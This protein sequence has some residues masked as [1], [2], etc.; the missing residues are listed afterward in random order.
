MDKLTKEFTEE[1]D[2]GDSGQLL[3]L[4]TELLVLIL[5]FLRSFRDKIKFRYVSRRL[6]SVIETPSL[7]REFVW[8]YYDDREEVC[9]NNVLKT[10][11]KYVK[12]MAFPDHVTA[13][14]LVEMLQYC[15]GVT[16]L[17]LP[18]GTKFN[19]RQLRKS[20]EHMGHLECLDV[21]W[22]YGNVQPLLSIGVNLKELTVYV[23]Q[24]EPRHWMWGWMRNGFVPQT[25]NIITDVSISYVMEL[26]EAWPPANSYFGPSHFATLKFY[27]SLKVPLYIVPAMPK[28]QLQYG[29]MATLPFTKASNF[30][31]LGLEKDLLLITDSIFGGKKVR[32]AVTV[33]NKM[34][35]IQ[36][37]MPLRE[38]NGLTWFEATE[39][40]SGHLEQLAI[41]CPNLQQLKLQRN[42]NCLRSLQGLRSIAS[43]CQNL[44][45]L[46]LI[47]ISVNDVEDQMQLWEILSCMKKLT[48][49]CVDFCL[50]KHDTTLEERINCSCNLVLRAL[51]VHKGDVQSCSKCGTYGNF[52]T[53]LQ[54]SHFPMLSYCKLTKF[55]LHPSM[56]H[57]LVNSCSIL[58]SLII[59]CDRCFSLSRE[60]SLA[61]NYNLKQ[62]CLSS[63]WAVISDEFM[64]SVSAH[65]G[66]EHVILIVY[67]ITFSGIIAL[68]KNSP[69]LVMFRASVAQALEQDGIPDFKVLKQTL[70]ERFPCR[71][72]FSIG[73]YIV[74]QHYH[75]KINYD[76]LVG[77]DFKL[78]LWPITLGCL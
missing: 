71:K 31:I 28:F 29:P 4:P 8:P 18:E 35:R 78:S 64:E 76:L 6:G 27:T 56:V 70:M 68:V 1:R 34:F 40:Y 61:H 37:D 26:I 67:R 25:L 39:F 5:S 59:H 44:Q 21:H 17:S 2:F 51:E 66:L 32:K 11:G 12:R 52:V 22:R 63:H 3:S 16:H 14:K 43:K 15:S 69:M 10:C 9:I 53:E 49:L 42:S 13:S 36:V 23:T 46:N 74:Q 45:G 19:A 62:L 7:W 48:H 50:L 77:T 33:S 30:G 73:S 65:G 58:N 24:N 41:A 75:D 47:D 38:L 57:D 72:L 55:N 20:V 54:L 60:I